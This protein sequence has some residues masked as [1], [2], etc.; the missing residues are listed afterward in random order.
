MRYQMDWNGGHLDRQPTGQSKPVLNDAVKQSGHGEKTYM[1][2]RV[3][4][5]HSISFILKTVLRLCSFVF[6]GDAV[7]GM[8]LKH[9]KTCRNHVSSVRAVAACRG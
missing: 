6:F 5:S 9:A 7:A 2:W 3:S 1:G 4:G 8:F